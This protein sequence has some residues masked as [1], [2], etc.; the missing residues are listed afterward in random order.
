MD[1]LQRHRGV[2]TLVVGLLIV[3]INVANL[4]SG[5]GG[6]WGWIGAGCGALLIGIGL[7]QLRT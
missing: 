7:A 1:W 4:A 5:S 6:V 2:V 3:A